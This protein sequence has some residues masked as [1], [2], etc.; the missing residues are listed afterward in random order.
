MRKFIKKFRS[1]TRRHLDERG[2]VGLGYALFDALRWEILKCSPVFR[3]QIEE[4]LA[5]DEQY[6]VTTAGDVF[7]EQLDIPAG[8]KSTSYWYEPAPPWLI[9]DFIESVSLRLEDSTLVDLGSGKGRVLLVGSLYPFKHIRGIELAESLH[10]TAVKNIAKFSPA[11]KR[12]HD[13]T[14][15]CAD[16][17]TYSFPLTSLVVSLFNPFGAEVL[18]LVLENLVSSL[19]EHPRSCIIAYINP[20]HR[21]EIDC[22]KEFRVI[23]QT[24]RY[25]MYEYTP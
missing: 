24:K 21:E 23:K 12:C 14:A 19:R 10:Q 17:T 18:K 16:A 3:R 7:L 15:V 9:R 22:L 13:V 11:T 20:K 5:F 2:P 25:L 6:G 1:W 8:Q 4:H